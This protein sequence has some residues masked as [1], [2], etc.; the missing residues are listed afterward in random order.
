MTAAAKSEDG[1][2]AVVVAVL[3][4]ALR[5]SGLVEIQRFSAVIQRAP[6]TP[7]TFFLGFYRR[8]CSVSMG[9]DRADP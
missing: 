1:T 8:P 2:H 3:S 5:G 6:Q 7:I 9:P 4:L